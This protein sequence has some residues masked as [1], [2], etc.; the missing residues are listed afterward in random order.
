MGPLGRD[1][2]GIGTILVGLLQV[3]RDRHDISGVAAGVVL[4]LVGEVLHF[5]QAGSSCSV[6]P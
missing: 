2:Q 6:C 4:G 1:N 5:A 3:S